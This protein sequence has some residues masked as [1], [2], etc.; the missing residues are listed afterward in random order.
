MEND[1]AK[2]K[3]IVVIAVPS[4]EKARV[5][6]VSSGVFKACPYADNLVI[7]KETGVRVRLVTIAIR[8]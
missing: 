3:N 5:A 4:V 8:N 7:D 2:E 1:R 6:L